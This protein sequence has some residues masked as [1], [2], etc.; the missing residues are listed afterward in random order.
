LPGW[1]A[2]FR[3]LLFLDGIIVTH[4]WSWLL[5]RSEL[6]HLNL[7]GWYFI[8]SWDITPALQFLPL[9]L[10]FKLSSLYAFISK[11]KTTLN[12]KQSFIIFNISSKIYNICW[13]TGIYLKAFSL[14]AGFSTSIF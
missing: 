8:S 9:S 11:G 3:K 13:L 12:S 5:H 14:T 7:C 2:S 10:Y 4:K 1:K 6:K